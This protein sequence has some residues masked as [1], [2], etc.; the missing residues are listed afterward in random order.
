MVFAA[1]FIDYVPANHISLSG[2]NSDVRFDVHQV[3]FD[4]S[5]PVSHPTLNTLTKFFS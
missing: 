2:S 5:S 1:G 4:G 3:L